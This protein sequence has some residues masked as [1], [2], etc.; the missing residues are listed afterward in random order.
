[1]VSKDR[2]EQRETKWG[3][4]KKV[5]HFSTPS[6]GDCHTLP[7]TAWLATLLM[8][9]NPFQASYSNCT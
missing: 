8:F 5:P 1:M 4:R 3:D 6:L 9:T 2:L 7:T